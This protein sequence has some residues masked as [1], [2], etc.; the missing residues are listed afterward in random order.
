MKIEKI[1]VPPLVGIP[2]PMKPLQP[3]DF[4][5]LMN[6]LKKMVEKTPKKIEGL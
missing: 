6:V 4:T 5:R 3:L 2:K 1:K